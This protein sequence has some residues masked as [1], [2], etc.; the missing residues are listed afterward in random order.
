MDVQSL[1][2]PPV[3]LRYPLSTTTPTKKNMWRPKIRYYQESANWIERKYLLCSQRSSTIHQ[4]QNPKHKQECT[5]EKRIIECPGRK[6]GNASTCWPS[7][8]ILRFKHTK[9]TKTSSSL[10]KRIIKSPHRRKRR[11]REYSLSSDLT[12]CCDPNQEEQGSLEKGHYQESSS[13]KGYH[14][15]PQKK[16]KIEK[17][18]LTFFK[19]MIHC[20]DQ[21]NDTV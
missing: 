15:E 17:R 8:L 21:A 9:T 5:L 19:T 10:E 20:G 12:D 18:V 16:E 4:A 6:R 1:L 2:C 14:Q 3:L 11:K 7:K 13:K